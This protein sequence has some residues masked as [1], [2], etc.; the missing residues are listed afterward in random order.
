[1]K[2]R[3][4]F[5]MYELIDSPEGKL[6]YNAELF[7]EISGEYDFIT[8]ILSFG[9]DSAWKDRMVNE[10]PAMGKCECLDLACGT[11][12]VT[13]RL[14]KK[15]PQ[16]RI[17]GLDLTEA[18]VAYA[19]ARNNSANVSFTIQDMCRMNLPDNSFDIVTGGY[20]LR[21]APDVVKALKEIHRVMKA[22]GTGA[23]LDFS[24]PANRLFQ[25]AEFLLLKI[26]C[27]LWG[28]ILHRNPQLY[29]YI[30]ESLRRF[31]DGEQLKRMIAEMGFKNIRVRNH[32]FGIAQTIIFEKA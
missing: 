3:F 20:A 30:A 23:F 29:T 12:D 19:T 15:Y 31:P 32:Y 18:M 2:K 6:K 16:G 7:R 1:M 26:W 22:G 11:G 8:P 5:D 10:L 27:G 17:T 14:A 13:I 21:N 25:K 24:K 28:I 9:R 4:D